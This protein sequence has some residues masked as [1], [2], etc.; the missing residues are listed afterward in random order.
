ML[1]KETFVEAIEKLHKLN[2]AEQDLYDATDGAMQL[3]EWTPYS[4]V[5]DM[6][7]RMLEEAMDAEVDDLFGSDISYFIYDLEYGK[8]WT[9]T[10]I[11]DADG[12]PIDISTAEKLYDFLVFK[13]TS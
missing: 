11:T 6:Y 7:V 10:S 9:E 1:S 5:I 13:R 2:N 4:D 8:K 3:L 12:K